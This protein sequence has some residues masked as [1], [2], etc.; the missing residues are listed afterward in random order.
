MI[1]WFTA[2]S[3]EEPEGFMLVVHS[4]DPGEDSSDPRL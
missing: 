4:T 2:G 1:W 3:H